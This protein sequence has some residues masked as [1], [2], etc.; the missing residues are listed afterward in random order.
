M[1]EELT[2]RETLDRLLSHIYD[3]VSFEE[4]EET[5]ITLLESDEDFRS[6]ITDR[7]ISWEKQESLKNSFLELE[8]YVEAFNRMAADAVYGKLAK[9]AGFL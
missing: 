4:S 6:Y 9:C 3:E 8:P 1:Y 5:F 2:E 7:Y